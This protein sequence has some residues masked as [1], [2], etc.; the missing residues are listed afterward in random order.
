M[1]GGYGLVR[2]PTA[3]PAH[4]PQAPGRLDIARRGPRPVHSGVFQDI[5]PILGEW[6]GPTEG[7]TSGLSARKGHAAVQLHDQR[8]ERRSVHE[9]TG[10]V[11]VSPYR[12]LT[13]WR[14][15]GAIRASKAGVRLAI[16]AMDGNHV[17]VVAAANAVPA[18]RGFVWEKTS[19]AS[20]DSADRRAAGLSNRPRRVAPLDPEKGFVEQH[21]PMPLP[22][23]DVAEAA[24]GPYRWA[25]DGLGSCPK[26]ERSPPRGPRVGVRCQDRRAKGRSPASLGKR[27]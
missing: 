13:P 4:M 10:T 16:A 23:G 27:A 3:E 7:R 25:A 22:R 1:A 9:E 15:S 5:D 17:F 14:R 6:P 26:P 2:P 12:R 18:K 20:R 11:T 19:C 8:Q 21:Y 24:G